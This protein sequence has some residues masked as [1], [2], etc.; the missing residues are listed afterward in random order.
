MAQTT[1]DKAP[2]SQLAAMVTFEWGSQTAR[3]TSVSQDLTVTGEGSFLAEPT[4]EVRMDSRHGGLEDKP[5][6]GKISTD[7]EPF[8]TLSEGYA[9]APISVTLAHCDPLD[10]DNTYRVLAKGNLREAVHNANGDP[11]LS[12]FKVASRKALLA[13]VSLGLYTTP[14]C[15]WRF[16]DANCGVNPTVTEHAVLSVSDPNP[17]SLE[18]NRDIVGSIGSRDFTETKEWRRG[19]VEYEGLKILIREVEQ[20]SGTA[21]LTLS[22]VPPPSWDGQSVSMNPGCDKQLS[23]CRSVWDNDANF[24]GPGISIPKYNPIINTGGGDA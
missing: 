18:I 14:Y 20:V 13:G 17:T 1:L 4:L 2:A 12:R 22:K 21:L 15:Q 11:S 3:Y 16:G 19:F 7:R 5:H 10:P 23:T 8:A 6:S 24:Q 9:H